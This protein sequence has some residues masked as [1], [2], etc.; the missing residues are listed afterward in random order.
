MKKKRRPRA[1]LGLSGQYEAE[2]T[3]AVGS[4]GVL[5]HRAG[6]VTLCDDPVPATECKTNALPDH[7]HDHDRHY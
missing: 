5:K 7:D 4:F 2:K 3:D 6:F 1:C